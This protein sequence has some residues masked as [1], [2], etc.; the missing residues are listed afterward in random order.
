MLD[1]LTTHMTWRLSICFCL[2]P[3]PLP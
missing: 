1:D 2:Y 3:Q